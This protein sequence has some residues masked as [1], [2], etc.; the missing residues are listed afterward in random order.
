MT[1]KT[2]L[3]GHTYLFSD[4][5]EVLAKASEA[6]SGDTLAGLAASSTL[7]RI[8]AK[9]VLINLSV[10]CGTGFSPL[11]FPGGIFWLCLMV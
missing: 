8:A 3:Y 2:T 11:P 4:I 1:L 5:K 6:K 9:T 10:N 7:E